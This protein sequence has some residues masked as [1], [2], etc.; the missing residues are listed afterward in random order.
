ME[1]ERHLRLTNRSDG[2]HKFAHIRTLPSFVRSRGV[3]GSSPTPRGGKVLD[4]NRFTQASSTV[5]SALSVVSIAS[6]FCQ[7]HHHYYYYTKAPSRFDT[8]HRA[9]RSV[10]PVA[11]DQNERCFFFSFCFV[12][13]ATRLR[14]RRRQRMHIHS[15]LFAS[16]QQTDRP[17]RR[18]SGGD[19]VAP[20]G[21]GWLEGR[22][23]KFS[24]GTFT[25]GFEG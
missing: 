25:R 20:F 12:P 4:S 8:C 19:R 18:G 21:Q 3:K 1:G 13:K 15:R 6:L 5:Y 24:N 2:R 10:T 9:C 7:H 14:V 11:V 17:R 16:P 23:L 22:G